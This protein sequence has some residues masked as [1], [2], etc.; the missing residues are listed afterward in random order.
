M[1]LHEQVESSKE[2]LQTALSQLGVLQASAA[3][4]HVD[5]QR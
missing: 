3:Q 4:E 5:K 1:Q 2:Q